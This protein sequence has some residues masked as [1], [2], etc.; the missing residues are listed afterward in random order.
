MIMMMNN[1]NNEKTFVTLGWLLVYLLNFI[2][3]ILVKQ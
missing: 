2:I 1:N 3:N